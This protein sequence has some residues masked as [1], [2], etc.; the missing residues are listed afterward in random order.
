MKDKVPYFAM[1]RYV[2]L[3]DAL[4]VNALERVMKHVLRDEGVT[5]GTW[6]LEQLGLPRAGSRPREPG[7]RQ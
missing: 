1:P 7:R 2:D 3:R 4:P 6:D 5:P